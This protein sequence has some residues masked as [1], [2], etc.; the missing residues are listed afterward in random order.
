VTRSDEAASVPFAIERAEVFEVALPLREPFVTSFG[1]TASR[2]VVL[3][4]LTD[5]EGRIGWGEAAPL[6]HPFYLPDTV[7]GAFGVIA[8]YALPACLRAEIRH[9]GDAA[10]AMAPIRGNTFARAGVE[11][12]FWVLEAVRT[13][14]S[15]ADL[16][17]AGRDRIAVGESLGIK[18][19]VDDLLEEMALRLKEGYRRIK[20]K[21]APGW[22]LDVVREVRSA[23]GLDLMLQVDANA[24]YT[25]DDAPHL[26][27]LDVFGLACIEQ[28]LE[29]D[30]LL[31]HAELQRRIN[32]PVCLDETLRSWRDVRTALRI[33]ACRNVN[34]K[35][36]RVGGIAESLRIHDLCVEQGVPLWC[37]G[38]LESGIGR[39]ANIALAGLPGFDQPADMSPAAILYEQDLVDPTYQVD[40]EGFIPV[41]RDAGLG[42]PVIEQRVVAQ[43]VRRAELDRAGNV[44]NLE[45]EERR[46]P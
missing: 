6:D 44:T 3:V 31:G 16:L 36:G 11:Q 37:G 1:P 35:P 7:S 25:L 4:R 10:A 17:G 39:A 22:D 5:A 33:G 40:A 13:G 42:F 23:F 8:E 19:S 24:A 28:P 14:R 38:M 21:I 12:A 29:Y 20:L 45:I 46:S 41:P 32:T 15:L 18:A 26:A 27:A 43:T 34:L 2:H 9:P 30:D